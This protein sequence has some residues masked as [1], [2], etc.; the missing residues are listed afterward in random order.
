[1]QQKGLDM[2]IANDVSDQTIGFNS[3]NNAVTVLWRDGE[4]SLELASKTSIAQ[5]IMHL[6]AQQT[7]KND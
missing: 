2:M 1:M 5:K 4:T 7:Q 3:D 6:I